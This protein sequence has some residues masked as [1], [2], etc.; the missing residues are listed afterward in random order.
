MNHL[1]TLVLPV[2]A[3]AW[4][5]YIRIRRTIGYQPLAV[6]RLRTRIVI[7]AV[8]GVL[9]IA[10]GLVHPISFAGDAGGLLAG[11]AL[12][13]LAV[14]YLTFERRE[15]RWYYRTHVWIET[16]VLVL[17]LGR[18]LYRLFQTLHTGNASEGGAAEMEDPVTAGALFLFVCYYLLLSVALLRKHKSL[19]TAGGT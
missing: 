18:L 6:R 4:V 3:L 10:A 2:L 19:E 13:L 5:V 11:S 1:T 15:E 12:A 8:V 17:F 16:L 9:V 7:M 14:R